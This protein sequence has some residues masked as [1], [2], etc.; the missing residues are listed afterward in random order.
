MSMNN[1]SNTNTMNNASGTNTGSNAGNISEMNKLLFN[2]KIYLSRGNF[3]EAVYIGGGLIKEIGTSAAL[4]QKYPDAEHI[5][6]G[7]RTVIPGLNDSHLHFMQTGECM[8]QVAIEDASSIEDLIARCK[9]FMEENPH[10]VK[11]GI[12]AIGWNQDLFTDGG[13]LPC[14]HDLDRISTEIPI[15]LERVCGH[16]VSSNTKVIEIL[17]LDANSPQFPGGEYLR[18]ADGYPSGIYTGN[19]C[20]FAK[21]VIPDFSM[22]ERREMILETMKLAASYGLTSVQSNDVGTTFMD[23]PAAFAMFRDIYESNDGLLRFRHQ[24]CFNNLEEFKAYIA[25]GEFAKYKPDESARLTLGPLKLFKDGSLGA[26]TALMRSEYLDD[27]GNYGREWIESEEMTEYCRIAQENGMQVITHVIGDKAVEDTIDCYEEAIAGGENIFRHAL[28]H[29]QITDR[30]LLERIARSGICVMA[31]PIFLDYDMNVVEA[32]CGSEISSTSYAFKTLKD[33][34]VHV[35]YGTDAPVEF[36]N[37]FV[38]IYMA[39]TRKDRNG[40]PANGFYPAE[41]V[42]IYDAVDAYTYE[43]AY[44]EFMEDRKGRI[45]EGFYADLVLLDRDIFTIDP[46][47]IKDVMPLMTIVGGEIVYKKDFN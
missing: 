32:R 7:G 22:E 34:G 12:H 43:S 41:A 30:P 23:G 27:P 45:R 37:P 17:G 1:M 26:R 42:D 16:I 21:D 28:V 5:D 44:L 14:R 4:L 6:C 24:V 36:F 18:E 13:R 8:N 46:M 2:A 35:A 11:N 25:Q 33:L 20:N 40:R 3:A 39:V 15:V 38:N 9:R 19:A 29:C 10:R 47:S 31:Q